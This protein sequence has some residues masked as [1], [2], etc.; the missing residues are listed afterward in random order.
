MI[1]FHNDECI[2]SQAEALDWID[3]AIKYTKENVDEF[4]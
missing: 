4:V 2:N 1:P 3:R